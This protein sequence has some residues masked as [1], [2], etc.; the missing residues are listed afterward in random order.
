M[1]GLKKELENKVKVVLTEDQQKQ[2]TAYL[3]EKEKQQ[4]R[5]RLE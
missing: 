2:F 1:E 3:K 4:R 5:R